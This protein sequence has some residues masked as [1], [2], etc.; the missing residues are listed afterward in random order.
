MKNKKV[1]IAAV[2]CTILAFGAYYYHFSIEL[3]YKLSKSPGDWGILGSY[4]GGVLGPI[5]SFLTIFMLAS[6]LS[7][8]SEANKQL[9]EDIKNRER[10]Q[11]IESL[12]K[13][14]FTMLDS[15]RTAFSTL[16]ISLLDGDKEVT[17]RN[18]K[19]AKELLALI[20]DLESVHASEELI[21]KTLTDIDENGQLFSLVRVFY[22]M[23]KIVNDKMSEDSSFL[24]ED[25]ESLIKQIIHF[26]DYV[27]LLVVIKYTRYRA[28]E[29]T[30]YLKR[31]SMLIS[32]LSQFGYP[33]F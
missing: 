31:D 23:V 15:Q 3:N 1:I 30:N 2:V 26:T 29:I 10:Y 27:N 16:T 4:V 14:V 9:K 6:S 8:Q 20:R 24:E 25:R 19:A 28:T 17:Y 13:K 32:V 5:L 18:P 11:A 7:L 22:V 33:N 21:A 12:E